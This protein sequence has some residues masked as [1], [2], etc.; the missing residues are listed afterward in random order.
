M[1]KKSSKTSIKPFEGLPE[2]LT[3]NAY[4][5]LMVS[6]KG[7]DVAKD[8][9]IEKALKQKSSGSGYGFDGRDINFTFTNLSKFKAAVKAATKLKDVNIDE[10]CVFWEHPH[11]TNSIS[12]CDLDYELCCASIKY[13]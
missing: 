3:G 7:Y 6:Y 8:K 9:A 12:L 5:S 13:L 2:K 10:V 4:Y 11:W 1:K